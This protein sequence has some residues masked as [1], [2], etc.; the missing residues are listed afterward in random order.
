MRDLAA[1]Q[2]VVEEGISEFGHI[3][4]VC[5][6][7]GIGTICLGA[8]H[9]R[10]DVGRDDR[11]QP[12][13][14]V[15]DDQGGD[16]ADDRARA[17]WGDHHHQLGRRAVRV[18]QPCPLLGREARRRRH[19]ARAGAG[20]GAA[21]DPCQHGQPDDGEHAD[22]HVGRLHPPGPSRPREPDRDGHG[23]GVQGPQLPA[24]PVGR[25]R[26]HQ[27]RRAVAGIR[28]GSLRH[29]RGVA[30]RRRVLPEGRRDAAGASRSSGPTR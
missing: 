29:R 21:H 2:R 12:H 4:V 8:G 26:R 23:G 28:R 30:R 10:A 20:A 11:H 25:A 19:H 9:G 1:L 16:P 7:A 17:G 15:E 24:D 14:R 27:Q 22:D 18:P 6:N 5:A 3:D 13:R